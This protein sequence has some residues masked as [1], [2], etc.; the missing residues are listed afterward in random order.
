VHIVRDEIVH[1]VI[2]EISLFLAG[3]DQL[4]YVVKLIFESQEVFLKFFNSPAGSVS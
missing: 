3:I 2:G 1:L 4:L